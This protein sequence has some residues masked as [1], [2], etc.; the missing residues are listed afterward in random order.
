MQ[1]LRKSMDWEDHATALADT[2]VVPMNHSKMNYPIL[3]AM[4][5]S[6]VVPFAAQKAESGNEVKGRKNRSRCPTVGP[7]PIPMLDRFINSELALR[8]GQQGLIR[9]WSIEHDWREV[10][11]DRE[12]NLTTSVITY[13]MKD[14]RWCE[15]IG[16]AHKSNNI[17][18]V[19]SIQTMRYWQTCYDTECRFLS[20]RGKERD[21]PID[22]QKS[23]ND[24]LVD[25]AIMA[26]SNFEKA[27]LELNIDKH[28]IHS[29]NGKLSEDGLNPVRNMSGDSTIDDA[30]FEKALLEMNLDEHCQCKKN[31]IPQINERVSIKNAPLDNDMC[32]DASFEKALLTLNVD[33]KC[34]S[35]KKK[36]NIEEN[37]M[38]EYM[39]DTEENLEFEKA[40]MELNFDAIDHN[41]D[42]GNL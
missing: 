41:N 19:V 2:L 9:S 18:W 12:D 35:C 21:L 6:L 5:D 40:L 10:P 33:G 11:P 1:Q 25:R 31:I 3:P 38:E 24:M 20:F 28:D 17:M 32:A 37:E 29:D 26:D 30:S 39:K 23:I 4:D 27:L 42:N 13:S 15:R 16:R 22:V 8:G 7:S 14:N 36:K 34:A